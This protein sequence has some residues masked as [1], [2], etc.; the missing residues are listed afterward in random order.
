MSERR[1]GVCV[2]KSKVVP[3]ALSTEC[4]VCGVYDAMYVCNMCK[5]NVC[6]HDSIRT[7]KNDSYC[8]ICINDGETSPYIVAVVYNEKRR[9]CYT[10][11][12]RK[13][14]Y[15]M[16]GDWIRRKKDEWARSP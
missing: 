12:K 16:S 14:L 4:Q 8:K 1:S 9:T 5:R 10:E 13:L 3:K 6:M 7:K 2:N 11:A 15:I